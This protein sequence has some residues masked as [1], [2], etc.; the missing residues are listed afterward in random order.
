MKRF[1][2]KVNKDGPIPEHVPDL[3]K[4]WEWTGC[5]T[6]DGY[7]RL[8]PNIKA[9]RLSYELNVGELDPDKV[10]MHL[11]DNTVCVRPDHLKLDTTQENTADSKRKGRRAKGERSGQAKYNREIILRVRYL[12]EFGF[13]QK[14][15][16]A[17]TGMAQSHVSRI[18]RRETW[19]HIL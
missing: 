1:W 6:T 13:Q 12:Y 17:I 14:E 2:S 8:S 19:A 18:V 15:I 10:V 16:A 5:L 3:G 11:C 4:C 9:H 7:P